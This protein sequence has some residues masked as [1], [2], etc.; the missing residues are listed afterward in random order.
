MDYYFEIRLK[1]TKDAL[2]SILLNIVYEKIHRALFDLNATDIGVSFPEY[3]VKLGT[4]IRLHG[5]KERLQELSKSWRNIVLTKGTLRPVWSD[6]LSIEGSLLYVTTSV[7]EIPKNVKHRNISRKRPTMSMSKL[8]RLIKRREENADK[9]ISLEDIS[10]YR[11]KMFAQGLDNPYVD[12]WGE[13]KKQKYRRFF[14]FGELLNE[15]IKGEFDTFGL[16]KDATIPW[17]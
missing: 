1:P 17:F 8:R 9:G 2:E 16:S 15:L 5:P 4:L 12:I 11:S 3:K 13:K 10:S 7:S 6:S 14:G